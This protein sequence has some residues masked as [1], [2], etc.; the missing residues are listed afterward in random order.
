MKQAHEG[1]AVNYGEEEHSYGE[2]K[3]FLSMKDSQKLEDETW[4]LDSG[5]SN[6]MTGE[7]S[8]LSSIEYSY[9]SS[10]RLVDEKILD[11]IG[12]GEMQVLKKKGAMK[13]KNIYYTLNLKQSLLSIGQMLEKN[14]K[15]VFEDKMCKIYDKNHGK[16]LV[17][18]VHM[19]KNKL[20][21]FKFLEK[22]GGYVFMGIEDKSK[23]WNMRLGHLNF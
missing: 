12:K 21:P 19:T 9:K 4:L 18:I 20:F 3:L 17:T 23:L 5:C 7:K 10:V 11:I 2:E 1:K 15:L 13:V 16:R 22:D 8:L 6:H 14:Y